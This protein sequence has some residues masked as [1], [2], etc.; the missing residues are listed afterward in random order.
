MR[1]MLLCLC[2]VGCSA[3]AQQINDAVHQLRG[4]AQVAAQRHEALCTHPRPEAAVAATRP[5]PCSA[6]SACLKELDAVSQL[7]LRELQDMART[8]T[9]STRACMSTQASARS[10]C[11]AAGVGVSDGG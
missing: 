1:S 11:Q 7:C 5:A 9:T 10:R 2:L 3:G 8:G 6:L 4:L